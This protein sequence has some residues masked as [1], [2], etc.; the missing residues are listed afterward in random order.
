MFSTVAKLL[1][2]ASAIAPVA[3]VYAWVAAM[4]GHYSSA[5][6]ISIVC[7]LLLLAC[8][9]LFSAA[10]RNKETSGCLGQKPGCFGQMPRGMRAR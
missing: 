7:L 2:I 8:I 9:G 4:E 5:L 1:L 10:R 3:L 6:Y